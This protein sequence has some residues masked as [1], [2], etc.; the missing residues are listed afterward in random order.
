MWY[1]LGWDG[2][3]DGDVS[4]DVF[5]GSWGMES[6]GFLKRQKGKVRGCLVLGPCKYYILGHISRLRWTFHLL[7][8]K[9]HSSP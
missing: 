3:V 6:G 2:M 9:Q 7:Y 8:I 1:G 5:E 4:Y